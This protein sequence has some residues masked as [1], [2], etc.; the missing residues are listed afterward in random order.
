M[1]DKNQVKNMVESRF[2]KCYNW[3]M[4]WIGIVILLVV[5]GINVFVYIQ[6]INDFI[7]WYW[8]MWALTGIA[9]LIICMNLINLSFIVSGIL[10]LLYTVLAIVGFILPVLRKR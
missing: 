2:I 9:L 3:G 1:I 6:R 5:L 10:F 7:G 4:I 8:L